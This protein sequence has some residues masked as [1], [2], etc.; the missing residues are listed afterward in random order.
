MSTL[1][2]AA[3][4]VQDGA[5]TSG[6]GDL[7]GYLRVLEIGVILGRLWG[8]WAALRHLLPAGALRLSSPDDR[9]RRTLRGA[10][11][12]ATTGD[13]GSPRRLPA[14]PPRRGQ[15]QF[16]LRPPRATRQDRSPGRAGGRPERRRF[17]TSTRVTSASLGANLETEHVAGVVRQSHRIAGLPF[18]PPGLPPILFRSD[19]GAELPSLPERCGREN[20]FEFA[21]NRAASSATYAP[22]FLDPCVP[23]A[24]A[25]VGY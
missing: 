7:I 23:L 5:Y 20:F 25:A 1:A 21:F 15:P 2:A 18:G 24:A 6:N 19:F 9:R 8:R 10:A 11:L 16:H 4:H 3:S 17:T 13:A 12:Q 14:S 22:Q